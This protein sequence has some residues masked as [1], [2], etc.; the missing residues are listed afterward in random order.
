MSDMIGWIAAQAEETERPPFLPR[1]MGKAE[2]E[3]NE[4]RWRRGESA[5]REIWSLRA[6]QFPSSAASG[7]EVVPSDDLQD[8]LGEEL[9]AS[10][11]PLREEQIAQ[12]REEEGRRRVYRGRTVG[13]LRRYL[14]YSMET[15]R[16]P[17]ILGRELFRAKVTAYTVTTFED[18]VIFVHDMETCLYQ[19]DEF[20]RQLIGRHILQEH[21]QVETA[22]LLQC[23]ERTVR[24]LTPFALDQLSRVLLKMGMLERIER[25]VEK[26]CQ[27]G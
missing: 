5:G 12:L 14:Q 11:G 18:R 4:M 16:L 21:D 27:G 23:T 1:K 2:R 10:A 8:E 26:S 17:S 6:H 19:L 20:S 3:R 25:A 13:L 9:P 24:R 7:E 15:G 22:R